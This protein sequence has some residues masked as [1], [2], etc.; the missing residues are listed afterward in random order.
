MLACPVTLRA[1]RLFAEFT[2]SEILRS[3]RLLRMTKNEGFTKAGGVRD[4]PLKLPLF[5]PFG[6]Y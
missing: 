5:S 4:T 2:L 3:L 1:V 6:L